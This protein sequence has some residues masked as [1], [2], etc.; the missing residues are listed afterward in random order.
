MSTKSFSR[1]LVAVLILTFGVSIRAAAVKKGA[2]K[3]AEKKEST[4]VKGLKVE[5]VKKGT[6]DEAITGKT[7]S[8]H[9]TGWLT[10]GKKFDS[11]VD[12]GQPFEFKLG[13][14]QVIPGWDNG[15]A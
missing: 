3:G 10:D 5:D 11:S 1:L 4:A 9:Y 12:R 15:V 7:V 14:G 6:G 2:K 8:V 13:A